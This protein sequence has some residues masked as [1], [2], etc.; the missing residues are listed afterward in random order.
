MALEWLEYDNCNHLD[1][2]C[3]SAAFADAELQRAEINAL[4]EP[5]QLLF[6]SLIHGP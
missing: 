4:E 5:R 3:L 6:L 2:V 1:P